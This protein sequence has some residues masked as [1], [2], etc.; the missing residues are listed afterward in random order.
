[1]VFMTKSMRKIIVLFFL[2]SIEYAQCQSNDSIYFHSALNC[3]S[4]NPA[5]SI[6]WFT[7]FLNSHPTS[8][9]SYFFRATAK[10]MAKD[11]NGAVQDLTKCLNL[12]STN[13]AGQKFAADKEGCYVLRA[14]VK[15]QLDDYRGMIS[16][17]DAVILIN[18]L[19]KDAF[20]WRGIIKLAQYNDKSGCLDLSRA[21]ELGEPKA[22]DEIRKYCN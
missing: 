18:G 7:I 19:N 11:F 22:Y 20:Y 17:L 9:D 21:G 14:T 10:Y 12:L 16:D 13:S 3:T 6:E 5:K 4:T 1:M 8:I 2:V 15:Y